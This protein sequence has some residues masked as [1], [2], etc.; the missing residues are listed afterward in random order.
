MN[1]FN[2]SLFA[3]YVLKNNFNSHEN[4]YETY[5]KAYENKKPIILVEYPGNKY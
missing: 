5:V 1:F 4:I 3:S 2:Q